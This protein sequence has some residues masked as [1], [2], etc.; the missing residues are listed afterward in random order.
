MNQA[1]TSIYVTSSANPASYGTSV[2]YTATV[3]T[4]EACRPFPASV[5]NCARSAAATVAPMTIAIV[6]PAPV[7]DDGAL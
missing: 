1:P 4:D 5:L 3:V 2:T 7:S 6:W